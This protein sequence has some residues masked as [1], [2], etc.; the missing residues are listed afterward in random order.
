MGIHTPPNEIVLKIAR[1][2]YNLLCVGCFLKKK[3]VPSNNPILHP[4]QIDSIFYGSSKL[5]CER[6]S[7]SFLPCKD[8]RIFQT[9]IDRGIRSFIGRGICHKAV[10]KTST[11]HPLCSSYLETSIQ[12]V[13]SI[14]KATTCPAPPHKRAIK[15]SCESYQLT[16]GRKSKR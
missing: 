7:C 11:V 9:L 10:K 5:Y 15:A 6:P 13:S 1:E 4:I 14:R 3:L 8:K 12:S 16:G 2:L